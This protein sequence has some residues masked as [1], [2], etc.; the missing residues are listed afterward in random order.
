VTTPIRL[1]LVDPHVMFTDALASLVGAGDDFVVTAVRTGG[2]ALAT[3]ATCAP[4]VAVVE[5]AL[6]GIGGPATV[7]GLRALCP[8]TAVIALAESVEPEAVFEVLAAGASGVVSKALSAADL[9]H[10]IRAAAAGDPPPTS[11]RR[12]RHAPSSGVP[13]DGE[14]RAG[15]RRLTEREVSVLRLAATGMSNRRI[16]ESLF[17]SEHTVLGYLKSLSAKLGVHSKLQA[18]VLG[19]S[20]GLIPLPVTEPGD[21]Q[22]SADR[23]GRA[24]SSDGAG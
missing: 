22:V 17:L 14:R 21:P 10:A 11:E 3:A 16:A 1:L 5:I 6:S 24:A 18:V 7:R 20:E 8:D 9:M 2:E 19:I 12:R 4:D 23:S 13:R 15:D